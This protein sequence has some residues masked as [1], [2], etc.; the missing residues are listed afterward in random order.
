MKTK[1]KKEI[2]YGEALLGIKAGEAIEYE[3]YGE[4]GFLFNPG[5]DGPIE[6]IVWG[7]VLEALRV[8]PNDNPSDQE[9]DACVEACVILSS[10][11]DQLRQWI[12]PDTDWRRMKDKVLKAVFAYRDAHLKMA[13]PEGNA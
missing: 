7:R 9:I 13:K 4:T 5:L 10:N 3:R 8:G 12:K 6:T 2:D 1:T 11:D